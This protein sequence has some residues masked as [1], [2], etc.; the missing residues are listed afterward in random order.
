M[1]RKEVEQFMNHVFRGSEIKYTGVFMNPPSPDILI[2]TSIGDVDE[3]IKVHIMRKRYIE[4][5]M[6]K[7]EKF[8]N[9]KIHI[10]WI[11][12]NMKSHDTGTQ[13]H[14]ISAIEMVGDP[15][16]TANN[17]QI[18]NIWINTRQMEEFHNSLHP[19]DV[20]LVEDEA[21]KLNLETWLS[22]IRESLDLWVGV[23]HMINSTVVEYTITESDLPKTEPE[24][25]ERIP[26]ATKI[27]PKKVGPRRFTFDIKTTTNRIMSSRK[28]YEKSFYV[29]GYWRRSGDRLIWVSDHYRPKVGDRVTMRQLVI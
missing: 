11:E 27:G 9:S 28:P 3:D 22:V 18:N 17:I 12:L 2:K 24:K 4:H 26:Q 13:F 10:G 29:H 16:V 5:D 19:T 6:E 7:A 21:L 1:D 20:W 15:A 14:I 8:M 25:R 23:Q